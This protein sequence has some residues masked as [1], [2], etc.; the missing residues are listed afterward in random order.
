MATLLDKT[1]KRELWVGGRPYILA[2]SPLALKLTLKGKR[3]GVELQWEN[4][5]SGEAA[6]ATAL[7]ASLGR[8]SPAPKRESPPRRS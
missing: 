1:L 3:K 5:V 6:L 7:S 2:I 4:L 8:F